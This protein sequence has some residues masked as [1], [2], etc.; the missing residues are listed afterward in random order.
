MIELRPYQREAMD[1]FKAS[2]VQRGIIALPTG[3]GKTVLGLSLAK[4]LGGR[5]LWLAHRDELITQP[6]DTLKVIWPDADY[7]VVKAERD[8]PDKQIVFASIQTASRPKRLDRLQAS[9]RF[10][11]VVEDECHHSTSSTHLCVL[12][13]M[14]C[15]SKGLLASQCPCS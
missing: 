4:E 14:G 7:G 15:F 1:A 12:G 10:D 8:E 11:F 5:L 3:T 2:E 9:G 6:I 13:R